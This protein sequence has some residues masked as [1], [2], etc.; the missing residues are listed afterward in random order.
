MLESRRD[1]T[2]ASPTTKSLGFSR[3][4]ALSLAQKR[5][6]LEALEREQAKRENRKKQAQE[7]GLTEFVRY[8]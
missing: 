5:V 3:L 2:L 1:E 4:S 6:M 8:F 7:G